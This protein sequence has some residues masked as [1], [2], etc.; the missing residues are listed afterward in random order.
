[1]SVDQV[2]QLWPQVEKCA[3]GKTLVGPAV[4]NVHPSS[5]YD[6]FF[7]KCKNCRVDA[8]AIHSYSCDVGGMKNYVNTFK[9]YGKPLWLTEFACA[10]NPKAIPGNGGGSKAWN[11]ECA[12]MKGVV[13]YL[14]SEPSV[15]KFSWFSI[16][17]SYTGE[18]NLVTAGKLTQLG[19]CYNNL[20]GGNLM[21]NQSAVQ[22]QVAFV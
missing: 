8:I 4:A 1:M 13:P 19:E 10:D 5:W 6:D 17:S 7:S 20:I 2:V 22:E 15:A 3:A 12:Y 21:A 11:W 9:K 14:M 18:S 16:S